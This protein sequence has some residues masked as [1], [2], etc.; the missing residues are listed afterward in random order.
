M[1]LMSIHQCADFKIYFPLYNF[2]T[3]MSNEF[4]DVIIKKKLQQNKITYF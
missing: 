3:I 4:C 2:D 1:L